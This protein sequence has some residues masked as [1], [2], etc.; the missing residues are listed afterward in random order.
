MAGFKGI[1][2]AVFDVLAEVASGLSVAFSRKSFYEK[3]F[4]LEFGFKPW[5]I[6]HTLQ[7][8]EKRKYFIN[9]NGCFYPTRKAFLK[10]N[11]RK[12][13]KV[14]LTKKTKWDRQWRLIIFDIPE[15]KREIR[16][17]LR[18]KLRE[19]G[20][21]KIQHSVFVCPFNCEKEILKISNILDAHGWVYVLLTKSLGELEEKVRRYFKL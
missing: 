19:W 12:L 3:S 11:R 21:Y 8:L 1:T 14:K 15:S 4:M 5:Q 9:K 18:G 10:I 16:D 17:S 6:N 13:E 7:N 2:N 20:C